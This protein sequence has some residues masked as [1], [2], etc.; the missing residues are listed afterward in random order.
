MQ[1]EGRNISHYIRSNLWLR[2]HLIFLKPYK[3]SC[4]DPYEENSSKRSRILSEVTK[5]VNG[6]AGVSIWAPPT[7]KLCPSHHIVPLPRTRWRSTMEHFFNKTTQTTTKSTIVL[8]FAV[9]KAKIIYI[10][11]YVGPLC[12]SFFIKQ[13]HFWSHR[14]IILLLLG[15]S[16]Q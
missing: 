10:F 15:F 7:P 5:R 12:I 16:F 13:P 11:A 9:K 8:L 2:C 14:K 4:K 1:E 3:I 6:R